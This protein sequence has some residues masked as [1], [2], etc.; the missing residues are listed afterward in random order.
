MANGGK[1]MLEELYKEN[2]LPE[3]RHIPNTDITLGIHNIEHG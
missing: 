2:V 3:S 1:E